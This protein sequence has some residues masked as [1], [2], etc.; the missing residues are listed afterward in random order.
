MFEVIHYQKQEEERGGGSTGHI[1]FRTY[2][3]CM[4]IVAKRTVRNPMVR[5]S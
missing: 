5:A 3:S 2:Y 4:C 1:V